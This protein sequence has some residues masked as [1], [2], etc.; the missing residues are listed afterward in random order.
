M[1]SKIR[2]PV[3]FYPR[4]PGSGSWL[5]NLG[6]WIRDKPFRI[7]NSAGRLPVSVTDVFTGVLYF[8]LGYVELLVVLLCHVKNV[9]KH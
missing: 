7:R 6:I 9:L 1:Y 3:L 8:V 5:K 4:G 2:D